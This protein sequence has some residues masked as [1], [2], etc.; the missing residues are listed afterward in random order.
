MYRTKRKVYINQQDVDNKVAQQIREAVERYG[1]Y[2][3]GLTD[4]EYIIERIRINRENFQPTKKESVTAPPFSHVINPLNS[5]R[6]LPP[7]FNL[8]NEAT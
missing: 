2:D 5:R 7:D 4:D 1:S 3:F 6:D 8:F